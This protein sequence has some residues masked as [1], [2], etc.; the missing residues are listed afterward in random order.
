MLHDTIRRIREV[1]KLTQEEVA[2][3]LNLAVRTYT[4]LESGE[5]RMDWDRVR[6]VAELYDMSPEEL[7]AHDDKTVTHTFTGDHSQNAN[8]GPAYHCN[9][10]SGEKDLYE[11]MIAQLREEIGHLRQEV[12]FLREELRRDR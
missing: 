11:Q 4:R 8:N 3:R 12:A 9:F 7:V 1:H 5:T 2:E 6:A 10:Y